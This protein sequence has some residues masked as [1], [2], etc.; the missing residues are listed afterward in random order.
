MSGIMSK[1][2]VLLTLRFLLQFTA[3]PPASW[4]YFLLTLG[5][6]SMLIGIL[7]ALQEDDL[8]RLLAYSSIEN[9]GIVFTAL[10]LGALLA[11]HGLLTLATIAYAA[12]MLHTLNHAAFKSLLFLASGHIENET[13]TLDMNR[14]GGLAKR[15]RWTAG[16]FLVG[17]I[18]IS[19]LPPLN[20]FYSEWL[21][22]QSLVAT[23]DHAPD[24]ILLTS[25][26]TTLSLLALSG[27]LAVATFVKAQGITFHAL[28]RS[29]GAAVAHDPPR[30]ALAP[31]ALLALACVALALLA[32][33]LLQQTSRAIGTEL[34][35]TGPMVD[36]D[37]LALRIAPTSS[38]I[39]PLVVL[40]LLALLTLIPIAL[41]RGKITKMPSK[42]STVPVWACGYRTARPRSNYTS[43][44]MAKPLRMMFSTILLPARR[45]TRTNAVDAPR[46]HLR[47]EST[48]T[49]PI[50]R[51][52]YTPIVVTL[53]AFA[54]KLR[55]IQK[56]SVR[57]YISYILVVLILLIAY[58]SVSP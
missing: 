22:Y 48:P 34:L 3:A 4:G 44:A 37:A 47:L 19:A 36:N 15:M 16:F 50:E 31:L 18:A 7:Y 53:M 26:L 6:T 49:Y 9:L 54:D 29:E 35:A 11:A 46:T 42:L 24:P 51:Y 52:V 8:K 32:P 30:S 14:L 13:G 20:G 40:A 10:G 21:L 23:I 25:A 39:A 28:P 38:T 45:L 2:A 12:G 41:A 58:V 57:I 56:G 55:V 5:V 33:T 1:M 27:G 43:L 17:A